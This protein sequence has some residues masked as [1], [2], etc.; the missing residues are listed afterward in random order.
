MGANPESSVVSRDTASVI[1]EASNNVFSVPYLQDTIHCCTFHCLLLLSHP[2]Q[3]PALPIS[4]LAQNVLQKEIQNPLQR[5]TWPSHF[6]GTEILKEQIILKSELI[7]NKEK[8]KSKR[9]F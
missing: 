1:P 4:V 8:K 2:W 9:K 7:E 6:E 3:T 5:S